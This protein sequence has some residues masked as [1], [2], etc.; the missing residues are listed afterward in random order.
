MSLG[1]AAVKQAR[2]LE[3]DF[4]LAPRSGLENK[5]RV[6]RRGA[7]K[8][9]E[10]HDQS[11]NPNENHDFRVS[12]SCVNADIR[13]PEEF[14]SLTV[15]SQSVT[16]QNVPSTD[17]LA[18]K[19]AKTNRFTVK[20]VFGSQDEF[21]SLVTPKVLPTHLD[22]G[23]RLPIKSEEQRNRSPITTI[24]SSLQDHSSIKGS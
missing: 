1:K 15:S 8:V 18:K 12:S 7:A 17:S 5:L 2:T 10:K 4:T 11:S 23:K 21:P 20:N 3:L 13:N 24:N 22:N 14:P 9:P 19:L 16:K 6:G